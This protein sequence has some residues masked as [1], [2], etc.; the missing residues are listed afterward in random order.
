[1]TATATTTT[2]RYLDAL[3]RRVLFFDGAMGTQIHAAGLTPEDYG[4]LA[5]EGCGEALILYNPDV[6]ERI[7][8]DYF[9]AGA[10]VVETDTFQGSR[11]KLGEWGLAEHTLEIN[12][13][14][15]AIARRVADRWST[16][17][18]PRFVAGSIGP[19]GMLP[20]TDDPA[21]SKI[22]Y[23]EL[24]E[25]FYEQAQGLAEGGVDLFIVETMMDMLELR[26][27][28]TGINR[29]NRDRGES[30]PIQA[31]I[32]IDV[33]GR[34]LLGTDIQAVMATLEALPGVDIIGLN[35]G[36]GPE[37][38]REPIRFLSENS[39]RKLSVI[40]NAGIPL[41]VN[42]KA[43][44]PLGAEDMARELAEFVAEFGVNAVGGCCG[45]TPE[46]I[47]A[48]VAAVGDQA[49]KERIIV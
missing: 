46:H 3:D 11:L 44:F 14:A 42:D 17:E 9:A 41:N 27:A 21:L 48:L 16:P 49:P 10:D 40:P 32:F 34:M 7:H 22:S 45:T 8:E 2:S 15:A 6:I 19:T 43:V 36:V 26:A 37:H 1:M 35:C 39:R 31:Q 29:L 38:M 30:I 25:V 47:A 13:K 20:S 18:L 12:R 23:A 24:V 4:G 28:I 5:L 33:S